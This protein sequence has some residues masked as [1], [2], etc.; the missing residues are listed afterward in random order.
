MRLNIISDIHRNNLKAGNVV[1]ET[2]DPDML[3]PADYL[4]VAGDLGLKSTWNKVYK[5]LK[6]KTSDK[7]KDVLAIEGNHD[8][9]GKDTVLRFA[10]VDKAPKAKDAKYIDV[11]DGD[12]AIFGVSAW[13]P[14]D[15]NDRDG[16]VVERGMNDFNWIKGWSSRT[17]TEYF[18]ECCKWIREKYDQYE[19]LKRV[20]VT[21][22]GPRKELISDRYADEIS[23][24]GKY[25]GLN[26]TYCVCDDSFTDLKPDL[27]IWGHS[28]GFDDQTIDGVRYIRNAIGYHGMTWGYHDKYPEIIDTSHWYNTVVE[29]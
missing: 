22:T 25:F 23:A 10:N 1:W 16:W 19:G 29:V 8:L 11:V 15:I 17:Q 3:E 27:W 5:E 4:V 28:H 2:F 12:V 9:W 6:E 20:I 14:L 24:D 21:H 18:R 13:T 26:A 7:F